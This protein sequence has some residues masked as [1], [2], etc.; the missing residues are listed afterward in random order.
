MALKISSKSKYCM[1]CMRPKGYMGPCSECGFDT[2]TY[3]SS[4][5]FLPMGTVLYDNF[6]IGRVLGTGGFG[7][8]YVGLD[9]DRNQ[10]IA[11]KEFYLTGYVNRNCSISYEVSVSMSAD[12]ALYEANREKFVREAQILAKFNRE[13]GIAKVY[14]FF[15]ANNTAYI[16]ME[17][18]EGVTLKQYLHDNGQLGYKDTLAIMMPLMRSLNKIHGAGL[19]HRDISPDNIMV[20]PQGVK[21]L[22][23]GAARNYSEKNEHSLTVMLKVGYAPVE[24]YNSKG[25]QGP[26]TDVYAICATMFKCITGITPEDAMNRIY[27]DSQKSPGQL[28]INIPPAIE[29]AIMSGLAVREADRIP[30]IGTLIN[31]INRTDVFERLYPIEWVGENVLKSERE[32]QIEAGFTSGRDGEGHR[33]AGGPRL[34]TGEEY[35]KVSNSSHKNTTGTGPRLT[36]GNMSAPVNV[37]SSGRTTG[38]GPRLTGGIS[39]DYTEP[40]EEKNSGALVLI[41]IALTLVCIC[42]LV[43]IFIMAMKVGA[44]KS[45]MNHLGSMIKL[46]REA[47][48]FGNG[49]KVT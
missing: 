38:T 23:F 11:I 13:E 35:L 28:G 3:E 21:L 24:Q 17:F 45:G 8:T 48:F 7:I 6:M 37:T 5:Q 43:G 22:D 16:V 9:L 31:E 34:T 18:V 29:N 32:H 33:F 39:H 25:E 49:I 26:W 2:T 30:N 46:C 1:N 14:Q 20:S 10:K 42:I 27:S 15:R 12:K 44:S 47:I 41:G 19:I 40:E 4:D 36:G